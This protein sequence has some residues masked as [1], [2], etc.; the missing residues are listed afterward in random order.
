[1]SDM[2]I[3]IIALAIAGCV[4]GSSYMEVRKTEARS[5]MTPVQLC[6]QNALTQHDRMECMSKSEEGRAK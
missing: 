6:I 2:W 5:K 4:V 1:M 3:G